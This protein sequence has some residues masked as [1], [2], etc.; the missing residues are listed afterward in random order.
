MRLCNVGGPRWRH[1]NESAARIVQSIR[2]PHHCARGRWWSRARRAPAVAVVLLIGGTT[3]SWSQERIGGAEIVINIVEGNLVSGSVVP[4]A[5]GD[6]VY[7]DE[8]V[9]TRVD[10]KARLLLEDRSN[11]TIGPAS[12]SN[13]TALCNR[14]GSSLE[15][16]NNHSQPRKGD[17]QSGDWRRQQAFLHDCD[18]ERGNWH[19][20]L[21][22]LGAALRPKLIIGVA[23][24]ASEPIGLVSRL[25]LPISGETKPGHDALLK[26]FSSDGFRRPLCGTAQPAGLKRGRAVDGIPKPPRSRPV[27]VA[28]ALTGALDAGSCAI[29]GDAKLG[30]AVRIVAGPFVGGL[31][32][33]R[34]LH[35]KGRVRWGHPA[36][37]AAAGPGLGRG[38]SNHWLWG[39]DSPEVR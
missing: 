27:D 11:V 31:G 29:G 17:G 30:E 15:H 7:R 6:A 16:W 21:M 12:Q 8:G 3:A 39:S 14:A 37:L 35:G 22:R 9:R 33:L 28:E 18:A 24:D 36:R 26:P 34:R 2:E 1:A 13:L 19:T 38:A 5:Q 20:R 23:T 32:M 10:S 25:E 4:A